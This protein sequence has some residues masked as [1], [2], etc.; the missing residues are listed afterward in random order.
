M[1]RILSIDG[2][3]IRGVF[4]L[5]VLLQ[6]E[7]LLRQEYAKPDLVLADHFDLFAGTSTGAI[8]ATSLCWGMPV[9]EILDLYVNYGRTMF[10]PV[11]WYNFYKKLLVSRYE[12]KPLTL[13]LQRVFSEDG[14]GKVPAL[15]GT[16]RLKKLLLVVIRNQSTGSAW[17]LTNNPQALFSNPNNP[18][19]NLNIPLW[20]VVRA[21]TAAPVY[22]DPEEIVLGTQKHIFVDGSVTPYNNPAAIAALSAVLPCYRMGWPVGP[23]K[24]KLISIGSLRF[25]AGVPQNVKKLWIGYH[26]ANIPIALIQG[27]SWEQDLMCRCLGK[28]IF[29]EPLDVE[30]GD[31][32]GVNLPGE[33]WFSYVRY[34]RSYRAQELEALLRTDRKLAQLDAVKSI[35]LLREIGQVYA[36]ENVRLEHVL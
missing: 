2:G 19:C 12:A 1:K 24:L 17:P 27:I 3:G 23:E 9:Q 14:Q 25:T 35:P 20:K 29:G 18:D 5:E 6:I 33:R 36:K 10:Q 30:L 32:V 31:L 8:I 16:A 13:L 15:L 22:F 11:P 21:S 28:C 26:A 7:Q 4:S 34:N